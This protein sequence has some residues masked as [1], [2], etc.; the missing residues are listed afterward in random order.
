MPQEDN[1]YYVEIEEDNKLVLPSE[2][3]MEKKRK[4][5]NSKSF[6]NWKYVKWAA[7]IV[8]GLYLYFNFY[9]VKEWFFN[10]LKLNPSVYSFYL[11]FES[12]ISR[13]TILG[14]F[15]VS[16]L[17]SLFFLALPS[18]A[19]FIYYLGN[20]NYFFPVIILIMVAGNIVGLVFNYFFG[21]LLGER[22]LK[23]IFKEK[24]FWDY[25]DKIDRLG[26]IILFFGNIFPGPI[27]V[28]SI[29]YGG[30]K[31]NLRRYMFLCFMGRLIKYILLFI[32][33]YFFWDTLVGYYEILLNSFLS[34][35]GLF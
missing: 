4:K 18:E 26:G 19:L 25:K 10:V 17:G 2:I 33:F 3:E 28:L 7:I 6:I 16:I 12:Q 30:F 15:V 22:V 14:L 34:F 21:R 5:A 23:W 13:A 8:I 9:V 24:K 32:A 35:K 11:Y 27:E 31:F 1:D 29:F 20:T